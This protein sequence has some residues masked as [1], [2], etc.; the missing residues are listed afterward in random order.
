ML[1]IIS[2]RHNTRFYCT[3]ILGPLFFFAISAL[4]ISGIASKESFGGG[5][6]LGIFVACLSFYLTY[7]YFKNVPVIKIDER[8]ISFNR[9]KFLLADIADIQLT[10]KHN[11]PLIGTFLMEAAMIQFSNGKTRLIYGEM[12]ENS[13]LIKSYLKRVVIDKKTFKVQGSYN[14]EKSELD[15]EVYDI[16]KGNQFFTLQGIVLWVC[17][18]FFIFIAL[19]VG[20]WP[21]FLFIVVFLSFL[22]Y[23]LSWQMHYFKLSDRFLVVKNNNLFWKKDVYPLSD[24]RE[25]VFETRAK[26]PICLRVIT[27]EYKDKLYPANTLY[28]RTWL[29]LK[30]QLESKNIKV[31]NECL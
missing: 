8:H 4:M 13:W 17:I 11:F 20:M 12:Y 26:M 30:A 14:I 16:Y 24:I 15:S 2:R 19:K 22:F 1:P 18:A 6:V 9:T 29:A 25:V 31:R 7:K 21:A 5:V 28:M 10:G 27:N 3:I 23:N